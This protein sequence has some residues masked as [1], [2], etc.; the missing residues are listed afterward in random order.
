ML[1]DKTLDK[2]IPVPLYFQLKTLILDQIKSG[3]YPS[4][5]QIPT[6]IE[7]SKYYDINYAPINTI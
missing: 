3:K 1:N 6:E 4:G 7:I 5:S 2:N